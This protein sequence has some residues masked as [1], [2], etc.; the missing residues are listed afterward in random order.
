[1]SPAPSRR[2]CGASSRRT[3]SRLGSA[4]LACAF[5]AAV[6]AQTPEPG[7]RFAQSQDTAQWQSWSPRPEIS[8]EFAFDP[9]AGRTGGG[10]LKIATRRPTDYGAWR[11]VIN[12]LRGDRTYRF[13]AWYR[14]ENIEQERHAI[15]TRLQWVDTAGTLLKPGIRP[16]E[17]P[18]D[19]GRDG[20][21][22]KVEAVV[23]APEAAAGLE[24]QLSLGFAARGVV[25]WDDISVV[26]EPN[27][28]Q[29][30]VRGMTIHHRPRDS[31]SPEA[32]V[33]KFCALIREAAASKP[34]IVCLPEGI[35]VVGTGRTYADVSEPIPGPTTERLGAV[36]RELRTYIVAG[37]YERAEPAVYNTAVLID[38]HGKL[39]GTYRKTHLP[40]EEWEAG[41][42]P[43]HSYPVF[44]TD[45]GRI[46]MLICWD[47]QFP[48]PWRAL[49]LQGAEVVL[50]PIW[51]G[52][53]KLIPARAI[54]NHVF[55]V[56]SCYGHNSRIVNPVGEY[57]AEG[58]GKSPVAVAEMHLD[59]KIY[60]T[61][62][63]DMST[64]TWKE[65]RGD[66]PFGTPGSQ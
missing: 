59:R 54:E 41:I 18:L 22:T 35:T 36:A 48:E 50:L 66:L 40:R 15:I 64:R 61:W 2:F 53:E 1:M 9:Q 62:I 24:V 32:N 60:Q 14:A 44:D 27:P 49:A 21:W 19:V 30:V 55:I 65:R 31:K 57:L 47:L 5:V 12:D 25:W 51:G 10:A 17:F 43:G 46:G 11:R 39:A 13:T 33:E 29:R 3:T 38:R 20:A 28:R 6:Q 26:E 45:F 63:G 8:P 16:P 52:N 4:L 34:D 56:T 58:S 42:A 37:I 7:Y 23:R